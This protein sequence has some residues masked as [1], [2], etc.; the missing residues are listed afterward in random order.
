MFALK[1]AATSIIVAHNHPSGYM[2]PSQEDK[3]ITKKLVLA[4]EMIGIPLLDHLIFGSFGEPIFSFQE[5]G[6]I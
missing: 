3:A 6:L 5:R 1:A 4:G 2:V